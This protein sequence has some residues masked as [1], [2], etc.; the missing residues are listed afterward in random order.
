[1]RPCIEECRSLWYAKSK[2]NSRPRRLIVRA[3]PG[4]CADTGITKKLPKNIQHQLTRP[5][6]KLIV[7][8][9][10]IQKAAQSVFPCRRAPQR[11]KIE[12]SI[13]YCITVNRLRVADMDGQVATEM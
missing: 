6:Q 10:Q 2:S 3:V 5:A 12:K 13:A 1:M 9:T 4:Y 7:Y 11:D 8:M